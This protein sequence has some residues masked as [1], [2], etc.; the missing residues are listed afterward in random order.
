MSLDVRWCSSGGGEPIEFTGDSA[1]PYICEHHVV[2]RSQHRKDHRSIASYDSH[3][4]GEADSRKFSLRVIRMIWIDLDG[5]D[6]T[7]KATCIRH[8]GRSISDAC[9]DLQ[10]T[11]G[12]DPVR[13]E[14]PDRSVV[15]RAGPRCALPIVDSPVVFPAMRMREFVQFVAQIDLTT[16]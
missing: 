11:P 7:P 9:A 6:L 4:V 5:V 10:K 16:E 2:G 3:S 1:S 15:G 8:E 12:M 14:S 13:Y